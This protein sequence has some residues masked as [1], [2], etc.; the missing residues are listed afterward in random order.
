MSVLIFPDRWTRAP[1]GPQEVN[2]GHHLSQYLISA[3]T[4]DNG[5]GY[6]TNLVTRKLLTPLG[7]N[8]PAGGAA[9][10]I[11]GKRLSTN[12]RAMTA[13]RESGFP[14]NTTFD[15]VTTFAQMVHLSTSG[16]A[17]YFGHG[18]TGSPSNSPYFVGLLYYNS[19]ANHIR[20]GTNDNSTFVIVDSGLAP[21]LNVPQTYSGHA[22]SLGQTFITNGNRIIDNS[23]S[24]PATKTST[25][26][27]LGVGDIW[28]QGLNADSIIDV[29][30]T[31]IGPQMKSAGIEELHE[32]P[33]VLIKPLVARK[34]VFS[35]RSIVTGV[36]WMGDDAGGV[37][38]E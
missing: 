6:P 12:Q 30:Y 1:Q 20:F 19:S 26:T 7:G 18:Y 28:Q 36:V 31:F 17:Y 4:F 33:Y 8:M 15:G 27:F 23:T 14:D 11:S 29:G 2:W 24:I 38:V 25:E 10:G 37:W 9:N 5:V 35:A 22:S 13:L 34:Y 32:N 21:V 3:I 16:D